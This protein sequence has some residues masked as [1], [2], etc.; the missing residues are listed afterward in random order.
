ML[1]VRQLQRAPAA[2]LG[3]FETALGEMQV[4]HP[5]DQ[6]EHQVAL[7]GQL[8]G[9]AQRV[10]IERLRLGQTAA[11]DLELAPEFLRQHAL[12]RVAVPGGDLQRLVQR[13]LG[14]GEVAAAA[15]QA[16]QRVERVGPSQRVVGVA[17]HHQAALEVFA[18]DVP[19]AELEADDAEVERVSAD[20]FPAAR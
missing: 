19:L 11:V 17:R 14:G 18:G 15:V 4:A 13:Q 5:A 10:G 6:L 20:S 9:G 1:P 16:G 3:L 8:L 7:G 12:A 2:C